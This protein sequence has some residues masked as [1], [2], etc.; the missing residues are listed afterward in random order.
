M[1]QISVLLIIACLAGC[2]GASPEKTGLEGKPLP[3]FNI[4][5]TDSITGFN[6]NSIPAGKPVAIFYFTPFCPHCRAQTEEIV[7]DIKK[8]KDIQFYFVTAAPYAPVK[9][10]YK[11]FQ[12]EKYPNI[13]MGID[14]AR[15][16]SEYFKPAGVPFMAIYGK[17]KTLN[18]TFLGKIY[19]NQLK[20]VAEE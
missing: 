14:T 12:L 2:F 9:E 20:K 17:D 1:K 7:D 16:I 15:F 13:T 18:K 10:Y 3:A 4:V 5:L 11:Q 6:T 19:S 8:L